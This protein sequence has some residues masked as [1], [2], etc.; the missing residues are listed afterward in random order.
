[1][2]NYRIH[3]KQ[4]VENKS[5][6]LGPRSI[7]DHVPIPGNY[8]KGLNEEWDSRFHLD[9]GDKI[10]WDCWDTIVEKTLETKNNIYEHWDHHSNNERINKAILNISVYRPK[11]CF[12][13]LDDW[14]KLNLNWDID[15][16][17]HSTYESNQDLK[18]DLQIHTQ[19]KLNNFLWSNQEYIFDIFVRSTLENLHTL[20]YVARE[21]DCSLVIAQLQD[22]FYSLKTRWRALEHYLH[23]VLLPYKRDTVDM[24]S[25]ETKHLLDFYAIGFPWLDT[26]DVLMSTN[27]LE[28]LIPGSTDFFNRDGQHY[29]AKKLIDKALWIKSESGLDFLHKRQN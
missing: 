19:M 6:F 15:V 26:K 17:L 10:P 21:F 2:I 9:Q 11:Y 27:R 18:T 23:G 3:L 29:A 14:I 8:K 13:I 24:V 5:V 25:N 20:C 22:P 12:V 4:P 16:D 7:T 1:M 28:H